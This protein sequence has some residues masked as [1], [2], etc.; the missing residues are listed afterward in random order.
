MY[1]NSKPETI[2]QKPE[3]KPVNGCFHGSKSTRSSTLAPDDSW[4]PKNLA[5]MEASGA[6]ADPPPRPESMM[7]ACD[8]SMAP[9]L[10]MMTAIAAEGTPA[11]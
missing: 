9:L 2:N 7:R 6:P 3:T 8:S 4:P 11:W 1:E 10:M 5:T